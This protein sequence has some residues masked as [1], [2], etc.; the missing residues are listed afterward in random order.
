MLDL[1]RDEAGTVRLL[2]MFLLQRR[3]TL[4]VE[5]HT[6]LQPIY[7]SSFILWTKFVI[8]ALFVRS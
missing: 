2:P 6:I 7:T 8:T 4:Y 3:N 5:H 1:L